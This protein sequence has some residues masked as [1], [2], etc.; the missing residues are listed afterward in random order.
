MFHETISQFALETMKTIQKAI[1]KTMM[2]LQYSTNNVFF[3]EK[4]K[5]TFLTV[6]NELS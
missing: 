4:L 6:A 3:N 1:A 5:F 2:A